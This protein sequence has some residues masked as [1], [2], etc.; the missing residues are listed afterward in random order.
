MKLSLI[1]ILFLLF[2]TACNS[3]QQVDVSHIPAVPVQIHRYEEAIFSLDPENFQAGLQQIQSEF[4]LFLGTDLSQEANTQPLF[5]FIS[6]PHLQDLYRDCMLAYPNL[7][8][9][10]EALTTAAQYLKYHWPNFKMPRVYSYISGLDFSTPVHYSDTVLLIPLDQYLGSDFALYPQLGLPRYKIN[11]MNPAA[12]LPDC[13]KE[14]GAS[15]LP[16]QTG[17]RLIDQMIEQGKIL[18]FTEQMLPDTEEHL[19]MSYSPEQTAWCKANESNLWAFLIDND[20]LFTTDIQK[21]AKLLNDGPFTSYFGHESPARLAHW[22][23]WN[24][25]SAYMQSHSQTSMQDLFNETDAQKI[26]A[27]S[28]YKPA[29]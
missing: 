6:D 4:P 3:P 19:L 11:R 14:I 26:L 22:V 18:Y 8:Q 16:K 20:L 15:R 21:T 12:I 10:E 5:E 24:I 23:G 13:M 9:Q 2:F 25:V 1:P 28:K 29:K 27:G 17:F 7:Q